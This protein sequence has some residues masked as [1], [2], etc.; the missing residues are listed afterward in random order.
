MSS[1]GLLGPVSGYQYEPK[2]IAG[3]KLKEGIWVLTVFLNMLLTSPPA[4]S[5]TFTSATSGV[6]WGYIE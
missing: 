6:F 2:T 1:Y 5:P 4:F 3:G